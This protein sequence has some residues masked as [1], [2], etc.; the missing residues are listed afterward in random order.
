M[1]AKLLYR[2]TLTPTQP[3]QVT[4]G[5]AVKG[6]P[7]TYEEGD[8]NFNQLNITKADSISPNL[9]GTPTAPTPPIGDDSTR[10]VTT[11]WFFQNLDA[12]LY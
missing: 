10:I 6:V 11:N 5:S 1:P 3:P 8:W 12:G 4:N 7:L 2:S 9:Q